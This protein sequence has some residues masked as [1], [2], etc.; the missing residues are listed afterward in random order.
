VEGEE[1]VEV[2][3]GWRVGGMRNQISR[4]QKEKEAHEDAT[5]G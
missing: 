1:E 2:G 5:H 3:G 4:G